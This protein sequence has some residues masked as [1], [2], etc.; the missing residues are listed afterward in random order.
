MIHSKSFVVNFCII[1]V[2]STLFSVDNASSQ[3][4]TSV[5]YDSLSQTDQAGAHNSAAKTNSGFVFSSQI[6]RRTP[7]DELF[8][9]TPWP[10]PQVNF[11]PTGQSIPAG[12]LFGNGRSATIRAYHAHDERSTDPCSYLYKT[13]IF[14]GGNTTTNHDLIIY[15]DLK[16]AGDI[17]GDGK[18]NLFSNRSGLKIYSFQS[19]SSYTSQSYSI[20]TLPGDLFG[21]GVDINGDGTDDLLGIH[22]PNITI[23]LSNA[24]DFG[25]SEVVSFNL[26]NEIQKALKFTASIT[27]SFS[28]FIKYKSKPAMMLLA[29]VNDANQPYEPG[30]YVAIVTLNEENEL[31]FVEFIRICTGAG[32]CSISNVFAV[33]VGIEDF[34]GILFSNILGSTRWNLVEPETGDEPTYSVAKPLTDYSTLIL[35][36]DLTSNGFTNMLIVTDGP[37]LRTAEIQGGPNTSLVNDRLLD[38]DFSISN[39][40]FSHNRFLLNYGDQTSNGFDDFL[41]GINTPDFRGQV[42]IEGNSS[43]NF[44]PT[45]IFYPLPSESLAQQ[46]FPAGD[47]TGNGADDFVI[48]YLTHN[49]RNSELV[50]YEG[51]ANWKSPKATWVLPPHMQP[52]DVVFGNFSSKAY[53]D[54]VILQR[55]QDDNFISKALIEIY[56]GGT[57]FEQ[58]PYITITPSD[59][60]PLFTAIDYEGLIANAGDVNGTGYDDL[61]VSYGSLGNHVGL[62]FGGASFNGGEPDVKFPN[63]WG[64][65]LQ[66]GFDVNGDGISDF[67]IG[68][69]SELNTALRTQTGINAGR[70]HIFLGADGVGPGTLPTYTLYADSLLSKSSPSGYN[71]LGMNEVAIGDFNGD[72]KIDFATAPAFHRSTTNTAEGFP[73]IHFYY[74]ADLK[75]DSINQPGKVLPIYNEFMAITNRLFPLPP[76]NVGSFPFTTYSFRLY[77]A[78]IPDIDGDGVDELLVMGASNLTNAVLYM[79]GSTV[80][81]T[82][83]I[84]FE[85]PIQELT[86]GHRYGG[87]LYVQTRT[88]IGDFTGD[89][90]TNFFGIQRDDR[91]FVNAPV[92]LFEITHNGTSVTKTDSE[93]PNEVILRQ[94]YPNPFNPTTT[95]RYGLPNSADVRIE[96]YNSIGQRVAVLIDEQ[97]IAGWHTVNFDGSRLSSGVYLYRLKAGRQI[98]TQKFTLIK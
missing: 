58:T 10:D 55:G 27:P 97:Q 63:M 76:V 72:G 83:A 37:Q 32:Q 67:I 15:D 25:Q 9:R 5:I 75:E 18:N 34:Q 86:M 31:V 68:N 17:N 16:P 66:G 24:D 94:N 59:Y 69:H 38:M 74:G 62:Y 44:E 28:G 20:P 7:K 13:L 98:V 85:A 52:R 23:L 19:A 84:L 35:M 48:W 80:D 49:S 33:D 22:S 79:G 71:N 53:K 95:I 57:E 64:S 77:M 2:L 29:I 11:W 8:V 92:Y 4:P 45:E 51:G 82:P 56:R 61:M 87:T 78:A 3:I 91:E 90:I 88:P 40:A 46:A 39:L 42:L 89:G 70:I 12:D 73:A 54:L 96:V 65:V 26:R 30:G 1:L 21:T 93:L 50:L 43:G 14:T 6:D 47:V 60:D 36:G 41:I 81:D